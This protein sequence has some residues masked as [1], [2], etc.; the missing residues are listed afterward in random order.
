MEAPSAVRAALSLTPDLEIS[1]N[2]VPEP[3]PRVPFKPVRVTM[4]T[5]DGHDAT[6]GV[7]EPPD[8][9]VGAVAAGIRSD[10]TLDAWGRSA[11]AARRALSSRTPCDI[12]GGMLFTAPCPEDTWPW[13]WLFRAQVYSALLLA[14]GESTNWV[15]SPDAEHLIDLLHG[16]VDWTTT[17]ALVGLTYRMRRDPSCSAQVL[18]SILELLERPMTPIWYLCAYKPAFQLLQHVPTLPPKTA[19]RVARRVVE[20]ES[21]DGVARGLSGAS[22]VARRRSICCLS[23]RCGG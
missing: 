10:F 12:L 6:P 13:T 23:P 2:E 21:E 17:A 3:D 1:F 5:Y 7:P 11:A 4:W 8:D 18:P 20:L 9:V 14:S 16:P 19:K 15:R 22:R